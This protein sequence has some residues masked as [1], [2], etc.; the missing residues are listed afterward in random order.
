MI[1]S[2]P[3]LKPKEVRGGKALCIHDTLTLILLKVLLS[4]SV[5]FLV[6]VELCDLLEEVLGI[7]E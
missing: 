6:A 5:G 1:L 4:G 7:V 3:N 2:V